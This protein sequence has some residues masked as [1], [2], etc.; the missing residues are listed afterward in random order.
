[1]A[2]VAKL[3]RPAAKRPSAAAA[4]A[5]ARLIRVQQS[6]LGAVERDLK[7]AGFPPLAWYDA[8]LEL[9][10]HQHGA[11]RPVELEKHM[12]L[13][14][15]SMSRLVDRMVEAGYVE[16]K[17]C[18]MDG[19]GQFVGITAPGRALQKKMWEVYAAAIERHV[20]AKLSNAEAANLA[21]VLGKLE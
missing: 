20:G 2:N 17:V 6:L 14:Q 16:R 19:R 8:L 9:S 15:Y 4:S 18:P 10:R 13:P 7:K 1:M 11:M 3:A 21:A 5:W 12:L